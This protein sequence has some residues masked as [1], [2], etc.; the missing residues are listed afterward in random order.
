MPPPL[1]LKVF[2]DKPFTNLCV[3]Q[4]LDI[5]DVLNAKV[6]II[7]EKL[8]L[9]NQI[10]NECFWHGK[11]VG[12]SEV[13]FFPADFDSLKSL[14][15]EL[16]VPRWVNAAVSHLTTFQHASDNGYG[17]FWNIDADDTFFCLTPKQVAE[18]LLQVQKKFENQHLDLCS[19][20]MWFSLNGGKHW[21]F[22]VCLTR[23]IPNFFNLL[24]HHKQACHK[25]FESIAENVRNLDFFITF[26]T[27]HEEKLKI[28]TFYVKNAAFTH[29]GLFLAQYPGVGTTIWCNGELLLP[30]IQGDLPYS[31][32]IPDDTIEIDIGLHPPVGASRICHNL[33]LTDEEIYRLHKLHLKYWFYS[34]MK[35]MGFKVNSY[36]RRAL[37]ARQQINTFIANV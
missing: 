27:K 34:F 20:D 19:L 2:T 13:S 10:K 18:I 5:A 24:I 29:Y 1:Y 37:R 7:C 36:E 33:Q 3:Q 32:P 8:K 35:K 30:F 22:G 16:V 17:C 28:G 14:A 26:L 31:Y 11:P 4:W 23:N 6:F 12:E 25:D 21:S 15:K 9:I